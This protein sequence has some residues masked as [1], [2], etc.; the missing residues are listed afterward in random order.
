MIKILAEV[1]IVVILATYIAVFSYRIAQDAEVRVD[2]TTAEFNPDIS[3]Q[4]KQQ[5]RDSK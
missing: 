3:T 4:Q 1:L 5:C 2:C